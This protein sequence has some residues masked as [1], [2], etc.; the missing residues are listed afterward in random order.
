M[1]DPVKSQVLR[2]ALGVL[3]VDV[4]AIAAYVA[5]RLGAAS[6]GARLAFIAIWIIATIAVV[7]IGLRRMNEARSAARRRPPTRQ[8]P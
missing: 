1:N 2:L 8:S 4:L 7:V 6:P 5:G 3:V